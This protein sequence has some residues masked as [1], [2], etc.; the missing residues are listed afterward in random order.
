M[1]EPQTLRTAFADAQKKSK[2]LA[3]LWD[4][5]ATGYQDKL[6]QA[7]ASYQRCLQIID[8]ISLFS[9]NESVDDIT[10]TDLQYVRRELR[11]CHR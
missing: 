1:E 8:S 7:I 9:A 5:S 6:V 10:S 11:C 3:G 4:S 2:D